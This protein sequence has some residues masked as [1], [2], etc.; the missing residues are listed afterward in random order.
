M[1]GNFDMHLFN[2]WN[3]MIVG[4]GEASFFICGGNNIKLGGDWSWLMILFMSNRNLRYL[5]L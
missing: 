5:K 4:E 1:Y 2:M 3:K